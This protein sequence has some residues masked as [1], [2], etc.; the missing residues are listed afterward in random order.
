MPE[1][2]LKAYIKQFRQYPIAFPFRVMSLLSKIIQRL[3]NHHGIKSRRLTSPENPASIP[4]SFR[5]TQFKISSS[6]FPSIIHQHDGLPDLLTCVF[7]PFTEPCH[8]LFLCLKHSHSSLLHILTHIH[9]RVH[10]HI[11]NYPTI[12]P[13]TPANCQVSADTSHPGESI[14]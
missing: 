8:L 6:S 14:S 10:A 7:C 4:H 3:P 11:H 12:I 5:A 2:F 9:T 1:F 13:L